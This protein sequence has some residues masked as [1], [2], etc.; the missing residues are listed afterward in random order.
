MNLV[1]ALRK[2]HV[3]VRLSQH[4]LQDAWNK[5]VFLTT[6]AGVTCL[7]RTDVGTIL[8]T[9]FGPDVIRK[10]FSECTSV[11]RSEGFPPD[12]EHVRSYLDLLTESGSKLTSSMLRDVESGRA[13]EYDHIL[14]DMLRRA[15]RQGLEAPL[16]ALCHLHLTCY[17]ARR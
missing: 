1:D 17:E 8:R 7:L 14:G 6:L 2:A 16:L 5:F 4:I 9:E 3:D 15:R 11:A 13:T 10:L 12:A